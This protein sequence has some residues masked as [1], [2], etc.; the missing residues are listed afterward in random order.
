MKTKEDVHRYPLSIFVKKL[1]DLVPEAER[2]TLLSQKAGVM[3]KYK[4]RIRV[5]AYIPCELYTVLDKFGAFTNGEAFFFTAL[6][7]EWADRKAMLLP[8]GNGGH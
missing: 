4:T 1:Y 2:K 8:N 7:A 3:N 5:Q 6:A